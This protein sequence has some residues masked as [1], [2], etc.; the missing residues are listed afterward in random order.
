MPGVLFKIGALGSAICSLV[1]LFALFGSLFLEREFTDGEKLLAFVAAA[2]LG[3]CW[4]LVALR[5]LQTRER[6]P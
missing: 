1:L 2:V 3:T 6:N 5:R 4:W